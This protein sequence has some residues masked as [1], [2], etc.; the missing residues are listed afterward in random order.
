MFGTESDAL[1]GCDTLLSGLEG[2]VCVCVCVRLWHLGAQRTQ[3]EHEE[4]M[5]E[6]LKWLEG[7][8]EKLIGLCH[9]VYAQ[10]LE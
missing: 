6:V 7:V 8:G 9:A 4:C 1:V 10:V 5:T 2:C 3:E